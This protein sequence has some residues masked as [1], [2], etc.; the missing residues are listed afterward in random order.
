MNLYN[1]NNGVIIIRNIN[2]LSK[3]L[4]NSFHSQIYKYLINN[5]KLVNI[6]N[7]SI[8][9][10]MLFIKRERIKNYFF[11]HVQNRD[12][13]LTKSRL[14]DTSE[15]QNEILC[16]SCGKCKCKVP[17][18]QSGKFFCCCCGIIQG[19]VDNNYFSLFDLPIQFD[20]SEKSLRKAFL[21]IQAELHP[22]KFSQKS[23]VFN[24]IIN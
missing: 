6:N 13:Y 15:Q 5:K 8:S 10:N 18:K 16:W 22:D 19:I 3:Y 23:E 11:H 9:S 2:S 14:I 1:I 7:K 21:R 20:L 12:F 17:P 24:M 4:S